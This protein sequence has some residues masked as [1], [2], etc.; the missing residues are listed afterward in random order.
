VVTY[1]RETESGV[2]AAERALAVLAAFDEDA[3]VLTLAK[4]AARTGMG[5]STLLRLLVSLVRTGFIERHDDGTYRIGSQAWRVGSLFTLD[6][7]L[8]KILL[9]IMEQLAARTKESVAFYVRLEGVTPPT[10]ICLLRVSAPRRVV[11]MYYV[12]NRLPLDR[13][14]GGRVVRAFTDLSYR[15]D[16]VI[17]EE[18]VCAAWGEADPE[19]CAVAAPVMGPDGRF[20]GALL[21]SAPCARHDP[22]WLELMKPVV[23]EA[24]IWATHSLKPLR[25]VS[26]SVAYG[27]SVEMTMGAAAKGISSSVNVLSPEANVESEQTFRKISG[28]K[29]KKSRK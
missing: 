2:A 5:K 16:D 17:R 1:N 11:H 22:D 10:R 25:S 18:G 19:V 8:E 4:L 28:N 23:M 29:S 15:E 3:P 6:L 9:P 27:P 13:G 21:L 14:A 24:A 7:S 12:G 26:G 20:V